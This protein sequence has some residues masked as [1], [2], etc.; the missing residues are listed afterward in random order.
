MIT[1]CPFCGGERELDGLGNAIC[2]FCGK[3]TKIKEGKNESFK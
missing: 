3:K 2:Y 1:K